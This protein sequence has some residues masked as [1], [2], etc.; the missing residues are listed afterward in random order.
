MVH[1]R[2]TRHTDRTRYGQPG[3]VTNLLP[4]VRAAG[5]SVEYVDDSDTLRRAR[6]T[7]CRMAIDV[8]D[9]CELL[10]RL[11]IDTVAQEEARARYEQTNQT[12]P[13]GAPVRPWN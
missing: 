11:G 1:R 8:E 4:T 6:L 5:G 3:D 9:A 2:V 7:V 13:T 10:R 12:G